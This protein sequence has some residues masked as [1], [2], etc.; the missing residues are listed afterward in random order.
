[1]GFEC[2]NGGGLLLINTYRSYAVKY[3]DTALKSCD[4]GWGHIC[5][6]ISW[7]SEFSATDV[8]DSRQISGEFSQQKSLTR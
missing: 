8:N 1:M 5:A 6:T 3:V 2:G 4:C 7:F